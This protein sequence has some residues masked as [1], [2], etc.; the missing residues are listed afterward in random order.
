MDRKT[1]HPLE[2]IGDIGVARCILLLKKPQ[3]S[4]RDAVVNKHH[5]DGIV[6]MLRP[7]VLK[8]QR[9]EV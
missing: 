3:E 6:Q 2:S 9:Q 7:D 5:R 8:G 4:K 1:V